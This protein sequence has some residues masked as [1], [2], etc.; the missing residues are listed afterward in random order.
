MN[1]AQ[2][3]RV[4]PMWRYLLG[5]CS[6]RNLPYYSS[7]RLKI[8]PCFP[9]DC[10]MNPGNVKISGEGAV[11]CLSMRF[12]GIVKNTAAHAANEVSRNAA[13]AL[14][15]SWQ[16]HSDVRAGSQDHAVG[17]IA[18]ALGGPEKEVVCILLSMTCDF[19]GMLMCILEKQLTHML[20]GVLLNKRID[21]WDQIDDMDLSMLKEIG[22][23]IAGAYI[24]S[25]ATMT[26][27][28]SASPRRR[29]PS[30]W[31]ARY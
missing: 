5:K 29:S 2:S 26:T 4:G 19:K 9:N 14:R 11:E 28:I 8:N 24:G 7:W 12:L 6:G 20:L 30:T 27:W 25:L 1:T 31:R 21:G 18:E 16:P 22:N 23:I 3:K 15:T 13:T 17:D 10:R